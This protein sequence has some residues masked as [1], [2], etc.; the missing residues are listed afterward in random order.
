LGRFPIAQKTFEAA[1]RN[2]PAAFGHHRVGCRLPQAAQG[3]LGHGIGG[4]AQ[5]VQVPRLTITAGNLFQGIEQDARANPAG[6]A[7]AARFAGRKAQK[8]TGNI[9]HAGALVQDN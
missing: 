1:N 9:H 2:L 7:V 5:R 8:E 3:G 6:G 4:T